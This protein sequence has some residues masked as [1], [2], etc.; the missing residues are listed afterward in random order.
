MSVAGGLL[1]LPEFNSQFPRMDT[2]TTTGETKAMNSTIQ[3]D[4]RSPS[5]SDLASPPRACS[6]CVSFFALVLCLCK[7]VLIFSAPG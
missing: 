1:T 4:S 3:G 5:L 6:T 2:I 7:S